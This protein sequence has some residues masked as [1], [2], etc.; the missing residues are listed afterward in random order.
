MKL[1]IILQNPKFKKIKLFLFENK[2][3]IIKWFSVGLLFMGITTFFVYIFVDI[4]LIPFIW[5]TLITG[6][7]CTILRFFINAIWVFGEEKLSWESC[8]KY[9]MANAG[10][11]LVWWTSANVITQLGVDYILASIL[12]VGASTLFSMYSNFFWVW[13]KK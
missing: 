13:R 1:L 7:L 4:L 12:A 2:L 9:H 5:A 8:L 10:A 3:K 11:F 6:E